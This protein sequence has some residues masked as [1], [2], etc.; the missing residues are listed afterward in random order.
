MRSGFANWLPALAAIAFCLP[1]LV[2]ASTPAHGDDWDRSYGHND[3]P[4][5]PGDYY[6]PRREH[7]CEH[8]AHAPRDLIV[9]DCSRTHRDMTW[10]VQSAVDRVRPNGKIM[11]LPPGEGMTCREHLT[12][13]KP[14]TISTY[15]NGRAAVIQAP[16]LQSCVDANVPLGDSLVFDGVTFIARGHS[17]PCIRVR[18]GQVVVRNSNIDSRNTDWAFDVLDS[19]E[20]TVQD[21]KIETDGSGI[22]AL[23][24]EVHLKGIEIDMSPA[25]RKA[26]MVLD[27]TDGDVDGGEIIGGRWGVV[28]SS[29]PHGL[30][31]SDIKIHSANTAVELLPGSQGSVR[32]SRLSLNDNR[33]GIVI[34]P[35]VDAE[36]ADNVIE[37]SQDVGIVLYETNARVV[38]NRISDGRIGIRLAHT[39]GEIAGDFWGDLDPNRYRPE[40]DPPQKGAPQISDN[41]I[42]DV[43]QADIAA[44]PG[45]HARVTG[46]QMVA[47]PGCVCI[48]H[49]EGLFARGNDCRNR[50]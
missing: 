23:R 32:V 45:T 40:D 47:R 38:H 36:V 24:A 30:A 42:D 19:G 22:H 6:P 44:D 14:V 11:I 41:F 26:A 13:T 4:V 8:H 10:S 1:F 34:A 18:A 17:A 9:V 16:D 28:A 15:G 50:H 2:P 12:I 31:V 37:G 5:A 48:S 20:L 27:R 35:Y 46:N 3:Y 21:T 49:P 7:C 43:D 33:T 29:G 39:G 25:R